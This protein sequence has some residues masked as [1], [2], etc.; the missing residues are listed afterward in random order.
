MNTNKLIFLTVVLLCILVSS[1][2]KNDVPNNTND[3]PEN[4]KSALVFEITNPDRC[5]IIE[6]GSLHDYIITVEGKVCDSLNY[7]TGVTINQS[8]VSLQNEG[9]YY[10]FSTELE[11]KW[12]MN[13]IEGLAENDIGGKI[14][15]VQSYIRSPEYYPSSYNGGEATY[16]SSAWSGRFGQE[17]IDDNDRSDMD[18]IA[19]LIT[20]FINDF[21]FDENIP[22][23]L[24][25]NISESSHDCWWPIP[26]QTNR[27]GSC[28]KKDGIVEVGDVI[29]NSLLSMPGRIDVDFNISSV[30]L[31]LQVDAYQDLFCVPPFETHERVS[32][33]IRMGN[34][35]VT[36]SFNVYNSDD[37]IEVTMG[38]SNIDLPDPVIYINV[39][40]ISWLENAI[41][42][43]LSKLASVFTSTIEEIINS[44]LNEDIVEI[45]YYTFDSFGIEQIMMIPEPINLNLSIGSDLRSLNLSE[46]YMDIF[47]EA[48]VSPSVYVKDAEQLTYGSIIGEKAEVSYANDDVIYG[49][50]VQD[51][52]LNQVFWAVW[53][54]GGFDVADGDIDFIKNLSSETGLE[55]NILSIETGLPPVMMA[56]DNGSEI[57]IS[58]GEILIRSMIYPQLLDQEDTGTSPVTI[59]TWV[60]MILYGNIEIEEGTGEFSF[61]QTN[62]PE[63]HVQI[64]D[65]EL[66]DAS[67]DL[68]ET[69][70]AFARGLFE[71][72]IN[73]VVREIDIPS[74]SVGGLVDISDG[75]DW[76]LAN[77][78][79]NYVHGY[80]KITGDIE[81]RETGR[82]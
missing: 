77:G 39:S 41:S 56:A 6:E 3:E 4:Q 11:G 53:A 65:H 43:T 14:S 44:F 16:I 81:I 5:A 60:S 69:L 40:G 82:K 52:F 27:S 25:N 73:T 48:L 74:L 37:G 54:G 15:L 21:N 80:H 29:I 10:T 70:G 19:S 12:G 62:A 2:R 79:I 36:S 76:V 7:V 68:Q 58:T 57:K 51:E 64:Q 50:G 26:D 24:A 34:I 18:D 22:E 59:S 20:S 38:E 72:Y 46:G 17:I 78:S 67:I 71:S 42:W 31:P 13:M 23:E 66:T 33:Y 9:D 45:L 8:D 35:N 61:V 32:G 55:A 47:L 30:K 75:T 63:I 49:L 28:I 1:C